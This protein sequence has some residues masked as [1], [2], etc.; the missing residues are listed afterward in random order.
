MKTVSTKV[1]FLMLVLAFVL[2]ANSVPAHA[3]DRSVNDVKVAILMENATVEVN[4]VVM[5]YRPYLVDGK[6][7]VP[8][9]MTKIMFNAVVH[10]DKIE[11]EFVM[12]PNVERYVPKH[13]LVDL[14]HADNK[15]AEYTVANFLC[16][17]N[18]YLEP[19][20]DPKFPEVKLPNI[21]WSAASD[22]LAL[23]NGE[24]YLP[25]EVLVDMAN[26]KDFN[27]ATTTVSYE[28]AKAPVSVFTFDA[29]VVAEVRSTYLVMPNEDKDEIVSLYAYSKYLNDKKHPED[30]ILG[31]WVVE[32]MLAVDGKNI[33]TSVVMTVEQQTEFV[34]V[35]GKLKE[36]IV[37]ERYKITKNH[38]VIDGAYAGQEVV[39]RYTYV[40][41]LDCGNKMVF[42][43]TSNFE[44]VK[45]PEEF[46]G[47]S[48]ESVIYFYG[49]TLHGYYNRTENPVVHYTR[50]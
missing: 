24:T 14:K 31:T 6:M 46:A 49:E 4:D 27:N 34:L 7:F 20:R 1:R 39:V 32:D 10:D 47:A 21:P 13:N 19:A 5:P 28:I 26:Y 41:F 35:D 3:I 25:L 36:V 9:D 45:A 40:D 2:I 33:R 12:D 50:K 23:I 38:T 30:K 42:N 22:S 48:M 29:A 44:L 43:R 15:V 17:A 18:V 8:L 37:P 11:R 16:G